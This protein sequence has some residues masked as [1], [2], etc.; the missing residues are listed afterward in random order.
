MGMQLSPEGEKT[1]RTRDTD[2]YIEIEIEAS[3]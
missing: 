1:E 3:I 2:R